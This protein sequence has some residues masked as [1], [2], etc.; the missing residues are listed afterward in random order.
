MAFDSQG[1]NRIRTGLAREEGDD[2]IVTGD[3]ALVGRPA[4]IATFADHRIAMAFALAGLRIP[5]LIIEDPACVAKT[6]PGYWDTL[7]ALGV[8][9]EF[10]A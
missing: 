4:R 1:L 10:G 5:D 6:W 7:A 9:L 8:R 3:P 2:L